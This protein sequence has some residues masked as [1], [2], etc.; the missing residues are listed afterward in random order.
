MHAF[1]RV[2][3]FVIAALAW[4]PD[5][6]F[7]SS[8]S[9]ECCATTFPFDYADV[10]AAGQGDLNDNIECDQRGVFAGRAIHNWGREQG[11]ES[12]LPQKLERGRQDAQIPPPTR[13]SFC[14]RASLKLFLATWTS[15]PSLRGYSRSYRGSQFSLRRHH[16]ADGGGNNQ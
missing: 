16:L 11:G 10:S 4:A 5:Y 13:K 15:S 1:N 2:F 14:K 3:L 6:R 9:E 12:S 8:M 7:D